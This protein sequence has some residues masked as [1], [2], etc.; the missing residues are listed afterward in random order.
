LPKPLRKSSQLHLQLPGIE[1]QAKPS[2]RRLDEIHELV[3]DKVPD[4]WWVPEE[5]HGKAEGWKPNETRHKDVQS[6]EF[7]RLKS[8]SGRK[9]IEK[10]LSK[11]LFLS[12]FKPMLEH[13]RAL[14]EL[15]RLNSEIARLGKGGKVN[16]SLTSRF[17]KGL[18]EELKARKREL[19]K[20]GFSPKELQDALKAESSQAQL[21]AV[22]VDA[23][24]KGLVGQDPKLAASRARKLALLKV[25]GGLSFDG[26]PEFE[27]KIILL[28]RIMVEVF[29][30]KW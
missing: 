12:R 6:I 17:F 27:R 5:I 24:I 13:I 30:K 28:E 8:L 4:K 7:K 1:V 2:K 23:R 26:L 18:L 19:L 14:D 29:E 20:R 16:G 25:N 10:A 22:S 3:R 9:A 15:V 11:D 21:L